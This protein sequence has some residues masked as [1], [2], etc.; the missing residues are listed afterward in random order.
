MEKVFLILAVVFLFWGV[1]SSIVMTSYCS[2]KGIKVNWLLIRLLIFKYVS[3]YRRLT[4]EE[5]GKPGFWFYSFIISMNSA[6]V[7]ALI[8][9]IFFK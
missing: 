1:A 6:L 4:I 5:T 2:D 8:F 9:L 3:E 7:F